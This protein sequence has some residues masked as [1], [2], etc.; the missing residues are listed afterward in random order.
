VS[1]IF[2]LAFTICFILFKGEAHSLD[3]I[4]RA[5]HVFDPV[6][7]Q[8]Q[9]NQ[10]LEIKSGKIS[11][12]TKVIKENNQKV[13]NLGDFYIVPGLIDAHTHLFLSDPTFEQDFS[14]GLLQFVTSTSHKDRKNLGEKRARSLLMKGFTAVRDLG[15]D[16]R[17][18]KHDINSDLR[19]YS[20]GPG[21]VPKWGQFPPGT[22]DK[23][24][25]QEYE[26]INPNTLKQL[27]DFKHIT[28]KIYAD[29]EPNETLTSPEV[30]KEWVKK[31]H[32]NN[33]KVAVHG[34]LPKAIQ[35]AIDAKADSL[36]HGTALNE[37][38]MKQMAAQKMVWVP[39]MGSKVLTRPELKTIKPHHVSKE[40]DLT[41]SKISKAKEMGVK[42]AFGSDNYFSLEKS[43]IS[44]GE[45]TLEALLFLSECNVSSSEIL[46]MATLHAAELIGDK[47]VGDLK[48]GSYADF[49]VYKKDP[50]KDLTVLKSPYKVFKAGQEVLQ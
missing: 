11:S 41:C 34:I 37:S 17:L 32:E 1:R 16:G 33:L 43:G 7:G 40:L 42:I 28:V 25:F 29:E 9:K 15:N 22:P 30:L 44:F 36:E 14:K 8:W 35:A 26:R 39:S 50:L 23:I 47:S 20:S 31:A 46:K 27:D 5:G 21:H 18:N 48:V 49:V 2:L 24:I 6:T 38:Q 12:I 13:I 10:Q 3:L 4:V 45:S 19:I